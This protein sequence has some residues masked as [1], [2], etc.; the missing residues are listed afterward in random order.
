MLSVDHKEH[1]Q[2]LSQR[3]KRDEVDLEKQDPNRSSS[4][5]PVS[6]STSVKDMA[7]V[8]EPD[9]NIV[10]TYT[11]TATLL[12]LLVLATSRVLRHDRSDGIATTTKRI[13]R[14][15]PEAASGL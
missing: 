9:P 11:H 5:E 2:T 3:Q 4:D 10:S 12:P 13:R 14:T 1:R 15:G 8:P 7:T 6:P